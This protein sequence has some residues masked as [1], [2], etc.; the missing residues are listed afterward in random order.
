MNAYIVVH[1]A[2]GTIWGAGLTE[3]SAQRSYRKVCD[4]AGEKATD[5]GMETLCARVDASR[6]RDIDGN[7][8]WS[9]E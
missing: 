9:R 2:S 1:S 6:I 5:E 7:T 4:A 8:S 3:K